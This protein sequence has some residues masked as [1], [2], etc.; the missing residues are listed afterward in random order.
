MPESSVCKRMA[1]MS[2]LQQNDSDDQRPVYQFWTMMQVWA[3]PVPEAPEPQGCAATLEKEA[4]EEQAE[5]PASPVAQ[6][7]SAA[8]WAAPGPEH[9]QLPSSAPHEA[10]HAEQGQHIE[11]APRQLGNVSQRDDVS[12]PA[13]QSHSAQFPPER[14]QSADAEDAAAPHPLLSTAPASATK[15]KAAS[16]NPFSHPLLQVTLANQCTYPVKH[17]RRYGLS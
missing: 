8:A 12:Q 3:E 15:C 6:S 4:A 13:Q 17:F 9:G 11:A 10:A 14:E 5:A 2:F 7:A 16:S 1:S